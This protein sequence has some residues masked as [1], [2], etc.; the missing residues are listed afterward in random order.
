MYSHAVV[1]FVYNRSEKFVFFL[2]KLK[3][4]LLLVPVP[5]FI[6]RDCVYFILCFCL[7]Q[8]DCFTVGPQTTP[9]CVCVCVCVNSLHKI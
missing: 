6:E 5:S 3:C 9:V 4:I 7:S 2:D 1:I 8:T